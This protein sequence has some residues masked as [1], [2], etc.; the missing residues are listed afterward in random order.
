MA[1]A[2]HAAVVT[3]SF[4]SLAPQIVSWAPYGSL[5]STEP[6]SVPEQNLKNKKSW[7][8]T[9]FPPGFMRCDYFIVDIKHS[10]DEKFAGSWFLLQSEAF[11]FRYLN[12]KACQKIEKD[13][14]QIIHQRTLNC[15]E[16]SD[17]SRFSTF[18]FFFLVLLALIL[19]AHSYLE[20]VSSHNFL[21]SY[22]YYYWLLYCNHSF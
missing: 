22:L 14:C 18:F 10:Y 3:P 1:L 20:I 15:S 9:M 16:F 13:F 17:T 7:F 6:R 4:K 5:L 11:L 12:D 8:N 19:I 21:G 2:L